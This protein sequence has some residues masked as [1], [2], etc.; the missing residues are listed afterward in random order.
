MT[1]IAICECDY[2][3]GL[4]HLKRSQIFLEQTRSLKITSDLCLIS[5]GNY[6]PSL[7]NTSIS[8]TSNFRHFPS[9]DEAVQFLTYTKT[10]SIESQKDGTYLFIDINISS[11]E[12]RYSIIQ[13]LQKHFTTI[14]IYSIINYLSDL[15]FDIHINPNYLLSNTNSSPVLN[16]NN[17]KS[18]K[19]LLGTQY[20]LF[21]VDLIKAVNSGKKN[22]YFKTTMGSKFHD[23][24]CE[25]LIIAGNTDPFNRID[26]INHCLSKLIDSEN[27]KFHIIIPQKNTNLDNSIFYKIS[28]EQVIFDLQI[29]KPD[30]CNSLTSILKFNY[31]FN[32][33]QKDLLEIYPYLDGAITAVGGTFWE[34]KQFDIPCLL[35]PG[36]ETE[37]QMAIW[38]NENKKATI[39][40]NHDEGFNSKLTDQIEAFLQEIKTK[41]NQNSLQEQAFKYT[42]HQNQN[43]LGINR[44][45][46]QILQS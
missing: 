38:L 1:L 3:I 20:R 2:E 33:T 5:F 18:S 19:F 32:T 11:K 28:S 44:I 12:N 23:D 46:A 39:L 16:Q 34:L 8:I 43:E 42:N 4:G 21:T 14:G 37:S 25:I 10:T 9:F 41:K 45:W 26:K 17:S 35:I 24:N 13:N 36:S 27:F 31:Y 30:K 7:K 15:P 29:I 40:L 6:S 22:R